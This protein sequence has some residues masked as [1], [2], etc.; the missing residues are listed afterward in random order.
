MISLHVTIFFEYISTWWYFLSKFKFIKSQMRFF[1]A[2]WWTPSEISVNLWCVI[3][4]CRKWGKLNLLKF[5]PL[6][7]PTHNLAKNRHPL[8]S[9]SFK[10]ESNQVT[11]DVMKFIWKSYCSKKLKFWISSYETT[12]L[13]WST[14]CLQIWESNSFI[15]KN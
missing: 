6:P 12:K 2:T 14:A 10:V 13:F 15:Y 9:S 5:Q 1:H 7:R 4:G 8:I 3:C 11:I